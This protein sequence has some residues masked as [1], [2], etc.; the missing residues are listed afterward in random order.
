MKAICSRCRCLVENGGHWLHQCCELLDK[1]FELV[2]EATHNGP[3]M[4]HVRWLI[5]SPQL[6][7]PPVHILLPRGVALCGFMLPR[8]P[9]QWPEGHTWVSFDDSKKATC[10]LCTVALAQARI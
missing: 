10:C 7:E 3:S 2:R 9:S 8:V 6:F 1:R 4:Q 5:D